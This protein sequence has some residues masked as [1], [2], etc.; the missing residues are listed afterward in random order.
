MRTGKS[1]Y[2]TKQASPA[3]ELVLLA[4]ATTGQNAFD[5][6]AESSVFAKAVRTT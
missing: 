5:T 2:W 3:S 6:S 1:D 4:A